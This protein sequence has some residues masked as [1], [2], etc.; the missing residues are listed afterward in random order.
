MKQWVD[1]AEEYIKSLA[2]FTLEMASDAAA[3][4]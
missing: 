1:G 3:S 4:P 2:P